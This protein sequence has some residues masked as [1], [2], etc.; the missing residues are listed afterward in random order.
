MIE[1]NNV[2]FILHLIKI[3]TIKKKKYAI[4]VGIKREL[5]KRT[6]KIIFQLPGKKHFN[7]IYACRFNNNKN[8]KSP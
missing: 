8:K 4:T 5:M 6:T 7:I 3:L 1:I 2:Y